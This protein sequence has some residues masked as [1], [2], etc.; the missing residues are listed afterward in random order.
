MQNCTH[1]EFGGLIGVSDIHVL[2]NK[3]PV[4]KLSDPIA[5]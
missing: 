3:K 1:K 4:L 5:N 2:G